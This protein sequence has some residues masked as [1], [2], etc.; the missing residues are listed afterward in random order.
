MTALPTF[1]EL[2]LQYVLADPD[3]KDRLREIP[4]QAAKAIA[5]STNKRVAIGQWV[6][7]VSRWMQSSGDE[8]L[9]SR[10]K[11]LDFLAATL[12]VL[13]KSTT[14]LNADQ[15]KLLVTFFGSLFENDHKA[16]ITASAKALRYLVSMKNFQPAL[17]D[18]VIRSVSKLADDFKLQAPTTRLEIYRLVQT[19]LRDSS[20]VS[21]LNAQHGDRAD[22]ILDL[23]N[24]CRNE[25]DPENLMTW[26]AI[27]SQL[28][29]LFNPTDE[30]TTEIFKTFS[31]YFPISLRPSAAPSA[32]TTEDLKMGLR[33]C[34]SAHHH[35]AGLSIPFLVDKLD[36]VDQTVA[37]KVDILHTLDACIA[38]YDDPE[39]T[40]GPHA[41]KIW[42]SLKYEVRNGEIQDIIKATLK[43]LSSL[44][45]RLYG[46]KLESFLENAWIDLKE[47]ISDSKYTAQAGRL[48]IAITG[49]TPRAFGSLM[50][51][52]VEHVKKTARQTTSD[53]HKRHLMAL[54]SSM[55]KLRLA[56]VSDPTFNP[57]EPHGRI[58]LSDELFGDSLLHDFY[59]PFWK[60]H[61]DASSPVEYLAILR[62]TMQ[63]LGALVGQN[64]SQQPSVRLCSD[65]SCETVFGL[66]A[67]P[68]IINP[69]EG[70]KFFDSAEEV[71]PQDL[72]DAGQEA[73]INAVP[74]YPPSFRYLLLQFLDSV[75]AAYKLHHQRP[76]EVALQIRPVASTLCA[77]SRSDRLTLDASWL[78]ETALINAFLQGLQWMLS[79]RADPFILGVF[80][81]AIHEVTKAVLLKAAVADDRITKE[82]FE[83][84]SAS[85]DAAG[86]PRIDLDRSGELE[87][88]H[89]ENT[90][91]ARSRRAYCILVIQQIYRRFTMVANPAFVSD[92]T[93]YNNLCAISLSKDFPGGDHG[94]VFREDLLLNR[95]GDLGAT[96]VKVLSEDE[97]KAL[98]LDREAFNFFNAGVTQNGLLTK[99]L[100]L[101]WGVSPANEFRT[102]PLSLGIIKGLWP[103]AIDP[104]LHKIALDDLVSALVTLPMPCSDTTRAA[105]DALLTILSNKFNA[106]QDS[107]LRG[108]R[109]QIEQPLIEKLHGIFEFGMSGNPRA[110]LRVFRSI[111][112]YLAGEIIRLPQAGVENTVLNF[113]IQRAP[114]DRMMGRD[115]AQNLGLLLAPRECLRSENHTLRKRLSAQWLYY[116]VVFP[117]MIRAFPD[118][119]ISEREAVNRAVAFFS[120]LRYVDYELYVTNVPQ[121]VRVALRSLSTFK[122]GSETESLL[123]VLLRILDKSP[124]E[125]REHLSGLVSGVIAIYRMAR[126]V[127]AAAKYMP[128]LDSNAGNE[129]GGNGESQTNY[130]SKSRRAI[131]RNP[132]LTRVY[133][134]RFLRQLPK[135]GY[136]AHLLLPL[137]K[138]LLRPL[139]AACGDSAREIRRAALEARQ[140]W[141]N[142]D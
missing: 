110:T 91:D 21:D 122:V 93:A 33:S 15:V 139:A 130:R 102:A 141:T 96:V 62:E 8:D 94:L 101:P 65:S 129:Q 78:Y 36:K 125:L 66:L 89:E 13:S 118:H 103:G 97:Q 135:S 54:L 37:V 137:R 71:V 81:D 72:L 18:Q 34:F 104:N 32:V 47:D 5:D 1:D 17:A 115:F 27:L 28:L 53:V 25:R 140:A 114:A 98:E 6:A 49:A 113:V 58:S 79:E 86:V 107:T 112:H 136:P 11:A 111:L 100:T 35:L 9:I 128:A 106:K 7:S 39:Q 119:L 134:L 92:D 127:A 2:A 50:P 82:W 41:D 76:F 44:T 77:I 30:V 80:V 56:L 68:V 109:A 70:T 61:S 55:L 24:L 90:G 131:D 73:L 31:A 3:E 84:F 74:L 126:S 59:L 38:K 10:A 40:I 16:G 51:R 69:I 95:T 46:D 23:L 133:A 52:A 121:I 108:R 132:I 99:E 20:V 12:E 142:L 45:R 120:L 26:F 87:I 22:F 19:L 42:G 124:D 83:R 138:E 60:E 116:K 4:E 57:A 105:M 64:S 14:V 75:K 85:L 63:G 88:L 67:K 123:V 43:V 117:H 29:Q 48:L